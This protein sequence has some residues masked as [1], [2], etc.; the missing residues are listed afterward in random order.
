MSSIIPY[1]C[2]ID[3]VSLSVYAILFEMKLTEKTLKSEIKFEGRIVKLIHDEIELPD[4]RIS[5]REVVQHPGGVCVACEKDDGE[6]LIVQQ[7]RYAF[8]EEILEFPAGKLE[9]GE[10]PLEA[11]MRELIEECGY[12]ALEVVPL[13]KFYPSV[14]YLTE[15]IYLYYVPKAK[16][17]GQCLDDQEFLNVLSY[18]LDQLNT[19]IQNDF[20]N[21]GKTIALVHKVE[22]YKETL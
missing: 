15:I 1:T 3:E 17:V 9:I 10:D 11:G 5:M 14:G 12:Q 13:G 21:D 4:G 19:L 22:K 20:I 7:F 18:P 2:T 16:F 8:K 6:F